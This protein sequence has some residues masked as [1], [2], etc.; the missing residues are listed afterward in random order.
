MIPYQ[1]VPGGVRLAVRLT[2]RAARDGLDGVT[3]DADGRPL[4]KIRLTAP[5]V[6]GE[7][8]AALAAFLAKS[9]RLKKAAIE[10]R[11]GETGRTKIL[12]LSGE[13]AQIRARLD[14]WIAKHT[15]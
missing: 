4:L 10:I 3:A 11:S 14:A 2:P 1:I 9:L 5:P 8:N 15:A 6:E 7:A 13:S 12:H